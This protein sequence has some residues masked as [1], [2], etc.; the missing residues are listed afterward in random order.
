M[1]GGAGDK[2]NSQ[3]L[4]NK[5]TTK[6][7][8]IKIYTLWPPKVT[9]PFQNTYLCTVIQFLTLVCQI[10]NYKLAESQTTLRLHFPCI[11]HHSPL[12]CDLLLNWLPQQQ[13][14]I[15]F[16]CKVILKI[17]ADAFQYILRKQT[18]LCI[19]LPFLCKVMADPNEIKLNLV[20]VQLF[21]FVLIFSLFCHTIWSYF[22]QLQVMIQHFNIALRK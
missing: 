5:Y 8:S 19:H 17:T 1:G 22:L 2:I 12:P 7:T 3:T 16:L 9:K 11:R 18:Y 21:V 6:H 14:V 4:L 10:K 15:R 13:N 20:Y